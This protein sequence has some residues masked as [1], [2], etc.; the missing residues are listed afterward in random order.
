MAEVRFSVSKWATWLP[1]QGAP[2]IDVVPPMQRRRLS[3]LT[4]SVVDVVSRVIGPTDCVPTVYVSRH[5]E[6]ISS[7]NM[8]RDLASATPLSPTAFSHSVHNGVVGQLSMLRQDA[9]EAVAL[10]AGHD[11]LPSA[12]FEAAGLLAEGAPQV[13]LIAADEALPVFYQATAV[14]D[15]GFA[16]AWLLGAEGTRFSIHSADSTAASAAGTEAARTLSRLLLGMAGEARLK[17]ERHDWLVK[18]SA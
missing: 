1:E 15:G 12:L 3:P 5:G 11:G 10:A 17:G 14:D 8:L 16:L 13:L 9:S 6:I 4:R 18:R 2:R 7:L